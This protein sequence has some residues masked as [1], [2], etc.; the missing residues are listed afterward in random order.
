M[1]WTLTTSGSAIIKAGVHA[2]TIT[3]SGTEMAK[4]SDEAEGIVEAKTRR[5][6]VANHAGLPTGIKG[7]LSDVTSSIIGMAIIGYDNTGY[8]SREADML[9]NFNDDRINKGLAILK[10]FKSNELK[11]P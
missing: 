6:W 4:M 11:T 8:L 1:S 7:I 9:M 5:T 3:A 2:S 10:D